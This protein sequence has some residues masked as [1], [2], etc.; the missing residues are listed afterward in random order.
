M[1]SQKNLNFRDKFEGQ[2]Q[3]QYFQTRPEPLDE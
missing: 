1:H 2:G 3:G